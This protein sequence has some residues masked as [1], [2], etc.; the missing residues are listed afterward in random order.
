[1]PQEARKAGAA[2]MLHEGEEVEPPACGAGGEP[3][4]VRSCS[5]PASRLNPSERRDRAVIGSDLCPSPKGQSVA[6]RP[7]AS[8]VQSGVDA[9]LSA[10]RSPVRIRHEA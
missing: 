3:V 2:L 9:R 1:M 5:L 6:G 10:E 8:S 4:R 7:Y